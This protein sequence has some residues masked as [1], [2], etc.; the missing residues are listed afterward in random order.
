MCLKQALDL[1]WLERAKFDTSKEVEHGGGSDGKEHVI[2]THEVDGLDFLQKFNAVRHTP[3]TGRF[4]RV[5]QHLQIFFLH[6]SQRV[7][8]LR[9]FNLSGNTLCQQP[10]LGIAS[11]ADDKRMIN[12][13]IEQALDGQIRRGICVFPG[14]RLRLLFG[15]VIGSGHKLL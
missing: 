9:A 10:T 14:N 12:R 3:L 2:F 7:T 5:R 6:V 11:S 8:L 13:I 1:G 4:G 15:V